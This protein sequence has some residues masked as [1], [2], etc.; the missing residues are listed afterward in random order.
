MARINDVQ[1]TQNFK[2]YEFECNDG[3]RE[4]KV[5]PE[6]IEK[7]QKLRDLVGKPIKI[8]SG[9]R[10]KEYNAKIGG[11]R[12]SQ[13][14]EGTAVDLALPKGLTVDKFA[15]HAE[16]IGFRGIGKY[17]WGIHV[18]VRETVARWDYRK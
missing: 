7:M 8:N 4:V 12:N 6:L 15:E 3:N 17:P 13:H 16:K 14:V 18:D 10:T 2:M 1:L 11:S 5:H 9:Y